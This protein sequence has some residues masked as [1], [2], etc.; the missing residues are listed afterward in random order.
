MTIKKVDVK[1][2][3]PIF[4]RM[5]VN[6]NPVQEPNLDPILK[7]YMIGGPNVDCDVRL[8]MDVKTLEYLLDTARRSQTHRVVI[9]RAGIR[10]KVRRSVKSGHVYETLHID[11]SK[12]Y[13]EQA[14]DKIQ[15]PLSSFIG[16]DLMR[17]R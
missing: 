1:L 6:N 17:N 5:F 7:E 11:G 12:P 4:N 13:P 9:N 3:A 14:P 10:I 8:I 2:E 16:T 15:M